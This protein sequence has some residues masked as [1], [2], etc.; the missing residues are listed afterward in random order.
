MKSLALI[1]A[2]ASLAFISAAE[3]PA[4]Y[5]SFGGVTA[6]SNPVTTR[7]YEAALKHCRPEAIN[8]PRGTREV[9]SLRYSA[10]LRAAFTGRAISTAAASPIRQI[11][12]LI[13]S[14]DFDRR[15]RGLGD[16]TFSQAD[17]VPVR[18]DSLNTRPAP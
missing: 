3:A 18:R 1:G 11:W 16:A 2:L 9:G 8:P 15:E 12:P 17:T 13:I 10:A 14:L 5:Q 7:H 6:D 4:N